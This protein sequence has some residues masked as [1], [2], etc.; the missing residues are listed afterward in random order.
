MSPEALVVKGGLDFRRLKLS[1]KEFCHLGDP[2][3][4]PLVPAP[5]SLALGFHQASLLQDSHV[6][7]NGRLRELDPLF[8]VRSAEPR[9]FADRASA[10][11]FQRA[12]NAPARRVRDGVQK[13]IQIG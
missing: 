7:R 12:Q 9:F 4:V 5:M 1:F 13:A 3:L 11:F 6:V 8:N 2:L 10:F